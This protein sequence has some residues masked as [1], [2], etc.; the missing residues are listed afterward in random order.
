M[1][2]I[3]C[4]RTKCRQ[5]IQDI[6]ANVGASKFSAGNL[7]LSIVHVGLADATKTPNMN[8]GEFRKRGLF[9]IV[10]S[11]MK[12][13]AGTTFPYAAAIVADAAAKPGII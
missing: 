9:W 8:P 10:F 2:W 11:A 3:P 5:I 12:G 6:I 13:R 7:P 4:S 1:T